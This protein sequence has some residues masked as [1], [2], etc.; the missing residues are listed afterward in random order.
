MR[1]IAGLTAVL[2][3]M[4]FGIAGQTRDTP[5]RSNAAIIAEFKAA[6][7]QGRQWQA[8][9]SERCNSARKAIKYYR[10]KAWEWEDALARTRSVTYNPERTPGRCAYIRF[11][12]KRWQARAAK[13]RSNY[14]TLAR[15]PF[16]YHIHVIR[17]TFPNATEHR[18]LGVALCETGNK[19]NKYAT[20][21]SSGTMGLFQIHP[22]NVGRIIH[23]R[24]HGSIVIPRN[25]YD[26][27]VN[28]RVAL[29]MSKGGKDWHE[30][31]GICQR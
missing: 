13:R 18:A 23:W 11:V 16:T 7:E 17:T 19:L 25:L 24:G 10:S 6:V 5:E 15:N 9:I 26:P 21:E 31:A 1:V 12:A 8:L 4:G 28:A 2:A 3:F 14:E 20:N 30:W 22:G 27:W 29:Y